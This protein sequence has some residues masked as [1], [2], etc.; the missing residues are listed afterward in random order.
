[1]TDCTIGGNYAYIGAG[2]YN[3]NSTASLYAS[4]IAQND[5]TTSGGGVYNLGTLA[6]ADTTISGNSAPQGGGLL[7]L[8]DAALAFCTVASNSASVGVG[9]IYNAGTATLDDTI[10]ASNRVGSIDSDVGGPN[11]AAVAGTYNLIGSGGSGGIQDGVDG[12][13]VLTDLLGLQL[14]PLGNYGGPTETMALYA[15]SVAIGAGTEFGGI[16]TDQRG[17]PLDTPVPDIG[18]Y[19]S[20]P[21][22][23]LYPTSPFLVT[24]TSDDGSVGTL[25]WAVYWADQ[26]TSP[27]SIGFYLGYAPATI[28]LTHGPLELSNT[29]EPITIVG[30]GVYTLTITADDASGVFQV[31][32]GVT[33]TFSWLTITG[34]SATL[35]GGL[36]DAGNATLT[37][38]TISG[39]TATEAGGGI[40]VGY[41]SSLNLSYSTI[42]GNSADRGGGLYN[43]NLA[44]L[45]NCTISGNSAI[46]GG[47][48]FNYGTATL[49]S[50][51]VG[52]NSGQGGGLYNYSSSG[53]VSTAKLTNTIVAGNTDGA[54][55]PD[56]I[57]GNLFDDVTGSYDL[58][59]TGGS[60]GI[61]DGVQGNIVL[62]SLANLGLAPL[63]NY[64]GPTQ[65][66]ALYFDSVAVGA[67]TEV[68]GIY[69]DQRGYS[70][71]YPLP[72]IGAF[73]NQPYSPIIPPFPTF[74]VTSTADDYSEGTLRWALQLASY[75]TTASTIEFDLG[76]TPATIALTDGTLG[77]GGNAP[78]T[79]DG[80]GADLLKI[81]GDY[82]PVFYSSAAGLVTL[83][84]LTITGGYG[85][86]GGGVD[87]YGNMAI[88]ACD[89]T[90][91][92]ASY[93]GGG[94]YVSNNA[95]LTITDS[96]ISDN[97]SE[98][99]GGGLSSIGDLTLTN[100]T[101]S[102]NTASRGGGIFS[103]GPAVVT[104]CTISGNIGEGGGL[105]QYSG[106]YRPSVATLT[107]TIVAG[108]TDITLTP[109]DIRENSIG[110]SV[111]AVTGTYNLIGTGGSGGIQD[112]A[113]GNIVLSSLAGLGLAPLA[114]YGGPTPT[115]ALYVGSE[116]IGTGTTVPDITTDQ[117]GEPLD[118][119]VPDIG[120][121]Q[122]QPDQPIYPPNPV[123]TVT[124]TADDGSAGTLRWAV[125]LADQSP[126]PAT[127]DFQLGTAP[128]M[129][130]LTQGP[131]VL[132]DDATIAIDGP[133]ADLLT[134]TANDASRVFQVDSGVTATLSGLTITGGS[135]SSGGGVY[136]RGTLTLAD[137]TISGNSAGA[138]GGGVFLGYPA[139][140]LTLVGCTITGN[141]AYEGGGLALYFPATLTNCTIAGNSATKGGGI[142]NYG[143]ATLTNCT[144]TGNSGQGGGLYNVVT[145]YYTSMA[146]LTNTIVAGN[147]D[148]ASNPDDIGGTSTSEVIGTNNLI[149]TGG[150]GGIVGGV[151]GNIVLTDLSGLDLSPLGD[152]GGPTPTIAL[153]PG[154]QAIGAGTEVVG[155]TTD[156]RGM[157]LNSL[158]L[159]IGAFQTQPALVVNTTIDGIGSPSGDLGLRQAV[160]LADVLGAAETI[161]FDANVFATPETITLTQGQLELSDADGMQ[162]ID[163]PAVGLT[164]SGNDSSRV[165]QL[166][167]GVTATLSGLTI[168]GGF[169][170]SR[171]GGIYN[172][173]GTLY[174]TDCTITGNS[175]GFAGGGLDNNWSATAYISD[176]TFS[177]NS[178]F[179]GGGL[180][181]DGEATLT[182]CT[183]SGNTAYRGGGL[184]NG[185]IATAVL[186]DCTVA[187]N[188][189]INYGGG[190]G[191]WNPGSLTVT[192]GYIENNSARDG[193]GLDTFG[194]ASVSG[195][196][197]TGNDAGYRGGGVY[198]SYFGSATLTDCTISGNSAQLAGG[199]VDNAWNATAY[200]SGCTLDGNFTALGGGIAN[201]GTA[202]LVECTIS[203][204]PVYYRGGG[205]YNGGIATA[206]LEYCTIDNNGAGYNGGGGIWNRGSLSANGCTIDGNTAL[207]GGGVSNGNSA[208]LTD[209]TISGNS[210]ATSG[211]GVYNSYFGTVTLSGCAIDSN[212]AG[213]AS[214]GGVYNRDMAT[215]TGCTITGNTAHHNGGGVYNDFD[216]TATIEGCTIVANSAEY[217]EGGGLD[218]LNMAT[219]TGC[220]IDENLAHYNGGGLYNSAAGTATITYCTISGNSADGTGG[221][222]Y[223]R[224]MATISDCTIGGNSAIEG[225]GVLSEG[226]V[227]LTDC[228]LTGNT[229]HNGGGLSNRG[230]ATLD[231]GSITGNSA[232]QGGGIY[233]GVQ[234]DVV[235]TVTGGT[236]TENSAFNGG[237]LADQPSTT[238]NLF[239]CT[240]SGNS[241]VAG[242]S[243]ALGGGLSV[244][245]TANL[246]D[247]NVDNNV[248]A[249]DGGGL[250]ISGTA[251]ITDSTI[252]G[253]SAYSGGGLVDNGMAT[254]VGCTIEGN[255]AAELAGGLFDGYPAALVVNDSTIS[256]NTASKGG[257]L[258]VYYHA[259]LTSCTIAGN[260]ASEGGAVFNYGTTSL[261]NCTVTGNSA[262]GGGLYNYS[263]PTYASMASL[264][265]TIIAGNTD[266]ADL[267]D[268]IGGNSPGEVT[269]MYNLIGTG[270]SGGLTAAGH[271]LLNVANPLLSPLGNYGGPTETVALLPG[272]QAIGT[273]IAIAGL[274]TDQRG[275][276]LPSIGIDIGAFQSQGFTITVASSSTPQSATVGT[277]FAHALAVTVTANDSLEPVAGGVIS[278]TD[279]SSGASAVLSS[280]SASIGMNG[281]ASIT[282]TANGT[283]GSYAVIASASGVATPG[284]FALTNTAAPPVNVTNDLS[285][286]LGGFVYNRTTRQFS[287]TVTIKNISNAAIVGPIDL[288]LLNLKNA[289]LV[290][291]TGTYQGSPYITV[292]SSGSLGIGQSLT[293]TLV[294]VDPTLAAISYTSEF[295]SGSI[296]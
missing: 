130:A 88:D 134:I 217:G 9:G 214:G 107:N 19:Q 67:G 174:L 138:Q 183:I 50:C 32:P 56:D 18:A 55:N 51:T 22:Q 76:S 133:G 252:D 116:A 280:H 288:L 234:S 218:N 144:I 140:P 235:L 64:G 103:A 27:S 165:F 172:V 124:S 28:T 286:K 263:S 283:T 97:S 259:T 70:L 24:S 197:I 108:N 166:D 296:G 73:Q 63:G 244:F 295:L 154:S 117:R 269:G 253:N 199:G 272:S 274:T 188:S 227:T 256:G 232:W 202:T 122:S 156:Q 281:A 177:G 15:G 113:Q 209:C 237:A 49:T 266:S 212:S 120:A 44:T 37:D 246:T 30:P 136:D 4:T 205:L 210:A 66:M 206:T 265:N 193:G 142:F 161:T 267:A 139:Q 294:F 114:N 2:L 292:L 216:G 84:G 196:T 194:N 42:S 176:S 54:D 85:Y 239:G 52:G 222:M 36:Y 87:V 25:R 26:L 38:C 251:T 11:A 248:S 201:D 223:N 191:I 180:V 110:A 275:V 135:A 192:G 5:A 225:G 238:A 245:G 47:G 45:T 182:G 109:D 181:N 62:T 78:I 162:T 264:T 258:D 278:F 127:I 99:E 290:G 1:M 279:P 132:N 240:I 273:G 276:A 33:A 261:T 221:G 98:F 125:Y 86:Y 236:I 81:Q 96:T 100:C 131:L 230:I 293:F 231:G 249:G 80:P 53:Y 60:G 77:L 190:G 229:A 198:N 90:G 35:G 46:E 285:V 40:F 151:G 115:L 123:Y 208:T 164:I 242:G 119:P 74:I 277:A 21:G 158:A 93:Y 41:P 31:D 83:S 270:G 155:V 169:S 59:G 14:A 8:G 243:S 48:I 291:Q 260:S 102:G 94:I 129:I 71:D 200:L 61:Q 175:A 186:D 16:T 171:G 160:N 43:Y 257:G 226:S 6:L 167:P 128:A 184:Y 254:L 23:P 12:N 255:S 157:L 170:N 149:G 207:F 178:S 215:L 262:A 247:C 146:T 228:N 224:G 287:Q 10:V 101:I 187:N 148:A 105:Y 195:C 79:I 282:A 69:Y 7:N 126:R 173:G 112:G 92:S 91:N 121:F 159:D 3:G 150:S 89:I 29:L 153:L 143:I 106:S 204:N 152:Y 58:I 213:N 168:T 82:G 185:G 219:V 163:G 104:S 271:N 189:A 137:C 211:G 220:P 141:S 118:T 20:Q 68:P 34:G 145:S 284:S 179:L 147:T 17:M 57:G 72:D 241:A 250:F 75:S 203:G 289:T 268:D 233:N 13:T 111:G 39:N 65:T 95:S